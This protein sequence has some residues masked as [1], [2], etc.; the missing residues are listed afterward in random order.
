MRP[1]PSTAS[2]HRR[3]DTSKDPNQRQDGLISVTEF[4]WWV[5][6]SADLEDSRMLRTMDK[7]DK[8]ITRTL[9]TKTLLA[10]TEVAK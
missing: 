10:D 1:H 6:D 8:A 9:S 7:I 5:A 4:G 2:L 3:Y